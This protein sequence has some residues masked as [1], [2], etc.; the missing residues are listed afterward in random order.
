MISRPFDILGKIVQD[1][2]DL[3]TVYPVYDESTWS[4]RN[5]NILPDAFLLKKGSTPLDLAFM[6]HSEIGE[7]FIRAIDC[8]TKMVI[9]K[10]H[11]LKEGDVIRIISKTK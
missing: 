8:K 9:G 3:I 7:G 6:V 5:G 2:L 11:E 1:I 4:D 10:D